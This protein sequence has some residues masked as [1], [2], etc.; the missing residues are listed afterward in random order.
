MGTS[1]VG[2]QLMRICLLNRYFDF[3]GTGVTRIATEVTTELR[4]QGHEVVQVATN[5]KSLYSYAYKTAIEAP[6]R[7]PRIGIDAYHALATLEALWL[8]KT[9]SIATF[10][11]LFTTTNPDRAGAGMGYSKWKL[12]IGRKYFDFGSKVAAKCRYLV[13]ISEKTKQDVI[14]YIKPDESKLRVIRLGIQ[15]DLVP[16]HKSNNVF[17][18]GTLSQL[19]KRKRIDLLIRQFKASKIDAEL[20]IAGQGSD[21]AMLQALA[22]GDKRIKFLGLVPNSELAEFYNSL[23]IF[24]FPTGIE[25]YG[26][27]AVEAM[28][29]N[30]PVIILNDA[31]IPDE[32]R[33]HCTSVENYTELFNSF[34]V[35]LNG[36]NS[37]AFARE[38]S[39][40]NCVGEYIKL[41]EAIKEDR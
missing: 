31:I 33:T 16:N 35:K 8:P 14:E 20:V 11:D 17:R 37:L 39:W 6:L 21:K 24:C 36:S 28:A 38:H 9:K 13:C 34:P 23:D 30:I 40:V 10:L 41:Y 15:N 1:K 7:L 5:G 3:R 25:G 32:V 4:N 2:A 27:P 12:A 29:C 26:L 19:D 22:N 18:I